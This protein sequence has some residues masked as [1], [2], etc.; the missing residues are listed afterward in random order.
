MTPDPTRRW[1]FF[2]CLCLCLACGGVDAAGY[3]EHGIFA[4]NMTGNT[5]LVGLA[6]AQRRWVDALD[7]AMPLAI[8]FLGAAMARLLLKIFR[9]SPWI[10]LLLAAALITLA[11]VTSGNVSLWLITLA[12]GLQC[13]AMTQFAGVTLSTVVITST[14]ARIAEALADRIWMNARRPL[15]ASRPP[16]QLYVL[17]WSCYL[18]GALAAGLSSFAAMLGAAL[19]LCAAAGASLLSERAMSKQDRP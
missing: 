14:M 9:Q 3:S 18:I 8:F 1:H 12:M 7:H 19:L 5:V 6:V 15:D 11:L 10:P 16:L 4:A 13:T 17:S 2:C